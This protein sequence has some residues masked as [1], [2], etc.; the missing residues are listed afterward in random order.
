MTRLHDLQDLGQS[1]WYDNIRRAMLDSGELQA[2]LDA[3][4]VGLTSNPSIFEKAIGGSADYDAAIAAA[5]ADSAPAGLFERLALDDIGRA[6]DLLRPIYER[7]GGLDGYASLE[8]NPHLAGDTEGTVAE[9]RRLFADLDRPNVMIKVP[10]TPAGIPA[11]RRLI[12]AG[13]PINVTL[14]FSLAAYEAVAHAYLD[15]L[16]D[17][18]AAGGSAPPASVASFFISRVDT[19][20]DAA[21]EAAGHDALRGTIGIANARQAYARF[22]AIFNGPR[23]QALADRGARVQ[24]P[25]WASTSTKD[26]AFPDTLYADALIGPDTVNTMP[27]ATLHAFLD[28]GTVAATLAA[29]QARDADRL[30]RLA[31]LGIDLETITAELL[32][33]GVAAFAASYDALLDAVARKQAALAAGARV[34][35][36]ELGKHDAAVE[37]ALASLQDERIMSHIWAHDHTVWRDDP[38][39]IA[40]RLGWLH[41]PENYAAQLGRI[42]ALV[43]TVRA[44]G[45]TDVLLLGMGGSS[46]APEVF[47]HTFGMREGYLDLAVCD[48][49]DPDAVRDHEARLDLART[50]FIVSTKSGG[51]V[52]TLSFFKYFYNRVLDT[53]G[54]EAAGAHFVAITDPGS[55]LV[56]LA[57]RY[58][59]RATFLNDPNIGGRYSALSYFGLLPAGLIGVDLPRLLD[60]AASEVCN[61]DGCNAVDAGDNRASRLGVIMAELARAGRDKLTFVLPPALASFGDWVE[62]L[63]AESTGKEGEGILPVVGEPIGGPEVYGDDRLFVHLRLAGEGAD[64]A[65]V[66]ALVAAGQPLVTLHLADLY[67]LGAQM[68][69]WEM[70]T[71]VAG[72]RLD[73]QPFDQPNVESAKVRA[74]EMVRAYA[75]EGALPDAPAAAPDR[76]TLLDFLAQAEAGDYVALQAYVPPRPETDVLLARLRLAIRD[77][78]RLATTVGYGPRFLHSTGQLHK[79]DAGNGLFVQFTSDAVVDL[80]IP[81]EAGADASAMPFGVLKNAQ[82]LGDYQALVDEERRVL[83][84]HLGT[85]VAGGLR[86][87]LA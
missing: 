77:R 73:I 70:A 72:H 48:S 1:V 3:G 80:A 74:T 4:V 40:N 64:T 49:T 60:R 15:G 54:P 41:A 35:E 82:A 76:A 27:P 61:S 59:F 10:A 83:R 42:T 39:E 46:L 85:D 18:F 22:R 66:R 79:G 67:D 21:L 31:E 58:R 19:K 11:I 47:R 52:E 5:P 30:R 13:I 75:S 65:A 33:E 50:L 12:A 25:L 69:L 86:R 16:D 51:T 57:R 44:D 53:V 34:M 20:A 37:R 28:H 87:L 56:D 78:T 2:L 23:W 68:F 62:Q 9:A 55:K 43:D 84:I 8:V 36:S 26:P 29:G 14:L 71:A 38:T 81:D 7:T 24:R 63:I 45:Y 32:E 17:F 6:A